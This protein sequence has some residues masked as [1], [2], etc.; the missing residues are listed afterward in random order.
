[1]INENP[2]GEKGVRKLLK[3]HFIDEKGFEALLTDDYET[4]CE[5]RKKQIQDA[6]KEKID[7]EI[8]WKK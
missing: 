5:A 3:D 7:M 1:M 6:I 4:F 8:T 2:N